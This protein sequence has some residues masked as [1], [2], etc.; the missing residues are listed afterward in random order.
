MLRK[1]GAHLLDYQSDLA[2]CSF[3]FYRTDHVH[4]YVPL[5]SFVPQES[6]AVFALLSSFS[7]P[8]SLFPQ[9]SFYP[10]KPVIFLCPPVVSFLFLSDHFPLFASILPVFSFPSVP[11]LFFLLPLPSS[12]SLFP[13]SS[14]FLLPSVYGYLVPVESVL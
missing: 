1:P 10:P 6:R 7:R 8:F 12:V 9:P 2:V 5:A 11:V 14:H 4:S 3:D 13:S